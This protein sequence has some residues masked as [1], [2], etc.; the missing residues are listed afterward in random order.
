MRRVITVVILAALAALLAFAAL[1]LSPR[2]RPKAPCQL[3]QINLKQIELAK[4]MWASNRATNGAPE[5]EDLRLY[6]LQLGYTNGQPLCPG[7]GTY[8][9]GALNEAPR[10]SVG[11]PH[12]LP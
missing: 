6:L 10:C 7:G 8:S 4:T 3:C 5:W 9:I 2:A 1:S 12:A 11:R